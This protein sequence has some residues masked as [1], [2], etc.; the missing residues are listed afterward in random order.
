MGFGLKTTTGIIAAILVTAVLVLRQAGSMVTSAALSSSY[1]TRDMSV[2]FT[3]FGMRAFF[4]FANVYLLTVSMRILGLLYISKKH[5]F[6]W[7]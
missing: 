6:G 7:F 1:T 4:S 3:A 2:L 5:K